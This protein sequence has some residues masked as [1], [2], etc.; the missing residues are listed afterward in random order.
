MPAASAR[1]HPWSR[2]SSCPGAC[3][4]L[5]IEN[6]TPMSRASSSSLVGG[7]R[8]SGRL[9]ISTATSCSRQASKTTFA[10]KVLPGRVPRLPVTRRPVQ[11]PST[12]IRGLAI[13]AVIRLVMP[14]AS[15]FSLE[16]TLATRTSSLRQQLVGLVERAVVEDVHLD[17]LEQGERSPPGAGQVV[18]DRLDDAELAGQPLGAEAVGHREARRVVGEHEVLVAELDRGERHLLDRRPA[19]GPVGVGVQ[20]AAQLRPQLASARDERAGV[21]LLELRQPLGYDAA[22]GVGDHLGSARADAGQLGEACRPRRG[23]P[24]RRPGAAGSPPRRRGRP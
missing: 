22:H 3:A 8:R 24:P 5:S 13:A 1:S 9:L 4:S 23:R 19:V 2:K 16:C 17:P 15:I 11:W 10:S 7:S 21:L 20:V 6:F 12:F 18:V 14:R